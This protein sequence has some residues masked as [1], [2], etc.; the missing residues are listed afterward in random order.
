MVEP[1]RHRQ[2]KGAATDMFYLTPP[3]HISTLPNSSF[4]PGACYF[5]STPNNGHHQTGPVG[6]FRAQKRTHAARQKEASF[7][8]MLG[9][10]EHAGGMVRPSAAQVPTSFRLRFRGARSTS[11]SSYP[12]CGAVVQLN[13]YYRIGRQARL[14]RRGVDA[15]DLAAEVERY[16]STD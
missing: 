5:R 10:R 7:V 4:W 1:L 3:R 16:V 11:H 8:H 2:T 15:I 12:Q 13:G 6:P 14:R 9:T